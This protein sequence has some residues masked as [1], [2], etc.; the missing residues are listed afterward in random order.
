MVVSGSWHSGY[1]WWN[2]GGLAVVLG[3]F[4]VISA[5]CWYL[6]LGFLLF[7]SLLPDDDGTERWRCVDNKP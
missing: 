3:G 4:A 1:W 2:P 5:G 7:L 6:E